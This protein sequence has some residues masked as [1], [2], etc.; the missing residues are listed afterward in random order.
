MSRLYFYLVE[1][2]A[3]RERT[4]HRRHMP[5]PRNGMSLALLTLNGIQRPMNYLGTTF[6]N[7]GLFMLLARVCEDDGFGGVNSQ[8]RN[9][10]R[11]SLCV[12][13]PR[14]QGPIIFFLAASAAHS[15]QTE[16]QKQVASV[17]WFIHLYSFISTTVDKT[18]LCHRAKIGLNVIIYM[19]ICMYVIKF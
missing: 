8:P 16:F 2:E 13:C 7:F 1:G 14:C 4:G 5:R 19:Y 3:A 9:E 10:C 11:Q 18:K 6:P 17:I 12:Q 15:S